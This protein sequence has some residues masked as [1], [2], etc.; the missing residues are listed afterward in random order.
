MAEWA[1]VASTLIA[2][3]GLF[4]AGAQLLVMNRSAAMDRRIALEGVVVSWRPIEAPRIAEADGNG[5]WLYEVRVHNPG[6]MPVDDVQVDW[7]FQCDVRRR[8]SGELDPPTRHLRLTVPVLPGG[9]NRV[10]ERRLV[11]KYHEAEAMLPKTFA[12]VAFVDID[13]RSQ[14]NTWPRSARTA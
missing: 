4:F 9:C 6:R 2:G 14:S 12:T 1:T 8:R 13:G 5:V 10:W 11:M 3:V 7:H